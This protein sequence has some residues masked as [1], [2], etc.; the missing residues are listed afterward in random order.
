VTLKD[1]FPVITLLLGSA[2]TVIGGLLS[3]AYRNRWA[4]RNAQQERDIQRRFDRIAFQRDTLLQ[5]QDAGLDL[6]DT[7]TSCLLQ[8]WPPPQQEGVAS[9]SQPRPHSVSSEAN[10]ARRKARLQIEKLLPRVEN[11]ELRQRVQELTDLSRQVIVLE[12]YELAR[13][14]L[15]DM[16]ARF[17][18]ANQNLL[19]PLFR[20]LLRQL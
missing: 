19:G 15:D 1:W 4:L 14:A 3:E 10:H 7:T 9:T 6:I 8:K 16:Q 11:D 5:L 20:D 13:K 18:H 17:A 12:H 2:L